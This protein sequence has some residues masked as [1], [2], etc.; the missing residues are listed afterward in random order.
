MKSVVDNRKV[1]Y[2]IG[3]GGFRACVEVLRSSAGILMS[4][5]ST[6]L[7]AAVKELVMSNDQYRSLVGVVNQV[8]SREV[9]FKHL[10]TFFG[11]LP[12]AVHRAFADELRVIF[13]RVVSA[14]PQENEIEFGPK[15]TSLYSALFDMYNVKGSDESLHG[16]MTH[17]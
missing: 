2:V 12:S 13:K 11:E 5:L 17:N 6:D 3:A 16:V 10:I 7:A 1:S 8:A 4:D 9:N 15:W 14:R